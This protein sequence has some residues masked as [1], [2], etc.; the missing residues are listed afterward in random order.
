MSDQT[1]VIPAAAVDVGYFSTK[2]VL[3]REGSE[4]RTMC[5]PSLAPQVVRDSPLAIGE[6]RLSGVQ[7]ALKGRDRTFFIGPDAAHRTSG[8]HVRAVSNDYAAS[9]EY[10]ALLWGAV[11]YIV[12]EQ[13]G[14]NAGRYGKVQISNLV[15]GL[16]LNTLAT[17]SETLRNMAV[18]QVTLP[19]VGRSG[20]VEVTVKRC[21]VLGQPQGALIAHQV[22]SGSKAIEGDALVIDIGGGTVDWY[23]TR[24]GKPMPERCGAYPKGMLSCA[25]AVL[26]RIAPEL[27]DDPVIVG[28]VD[29]ALQG[30]ELTA[31]IDGRLV[32]LKPHLPAAMDVLREGLARVMESIQSLASV[33][34]IVLAGGGAG[35]M[36]KAL[37]E[38]WPTRA[39]SVERSANPIYANVEG[40]FAM[41]ER[42]ARNA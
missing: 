22:A 34:T 15:L 7:I 21:F 24:G 37:K 41:A 32:D 6:G 2:L 29:Q 25:F 1:L 36:S 9:D 5:F 23:L 16:P 42:V 10:Q 30:D 14:K 38:S 28:R 8:R 12:S 13:L 19:L 4:L 26:E 11:A 33:D 18:T 27:R 17:H 40:F 35:L 20:T 39:D 3:R 31:R